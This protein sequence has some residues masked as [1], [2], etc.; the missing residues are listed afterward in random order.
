M[1]KKSSFLEKLV[2]RLRAGTTV[3]VSADEEGKEGVEGSREVIDAQAMAAESTPEAAHRRKLNPREDVVLA[4][5]ESFGELSSLLRGV[6]VR[7]EDQG[8]RLAD[9]GA[10]VQKL[11]LTAEQELEAVRDLAK[12]IEEQNQLSKSMLEAYA[13][14]PQVMLGVK[15]AL[16]RAAASDERTARTIEDF[17]SSMGHVQGS[18]REMVQ[19]SKEQSQSA[20]ALAKS[21]EN[22]VRQLESTTQE[23]LK[24]LRWAQE[25]QANRMIKL[26]GESSKWSRAVLVMLVMTFVVLACILG[27]ILVNG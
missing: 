17:R 15:E 23:G 1:V 14:L 26:V 27:A 19:S 2:G 16:Q 21:Q 10:H 25:D 7:M 11:P 22:S 3:R 20:A 13:D 18:M 24:A 5:N 6:Q 12:Q 4:M 8:G 9:M